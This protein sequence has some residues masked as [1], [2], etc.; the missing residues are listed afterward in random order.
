MHGD[1][2]ECARTLIQAVFRLAFCDYIGVAYGHDEPGPDKWTKLNPT[3]QTDAEKFLTS[4][5]AAHLGDL[6]GLTTRVVWKQAQ[7]NLLRRPAIVPKPEKAAAPKQLI[8]A[9]QEAAYRLQP[10]VEVAA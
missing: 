8:A 2:G 4:E 5:W 7:R 1:L 10:D 6:A 3:L 9:P